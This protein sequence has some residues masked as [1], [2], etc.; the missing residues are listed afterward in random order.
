[1]VCKDTAILDCWW[2]PQSD[3]VWCTTI[4]QTRVRGSRSSLGHIRGRRRLRRVLRSS[5]TG[6]QLSFWVDDA[7]IHQR[8]VSKST[9]LGKIAS[10]YTV[11]CIY[12]ILCVPNIP[13]SCHCVIL[14]THAAPIFVPRFHKPIPLYGNQWHACKHDFI[15]QDLI[16][17]LHTQVLP[18]AGKQHAET[19]QVGYDSWNWLNTSWHIFL[20]GVGIGV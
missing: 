4:S 12:A 8:N 11:N 7:F 9:A 3:G 14:V 18:T 17:T 20:H 1:M 10:P 19:T 5:Y 13:L 16:L 15:E 6:T 2:V